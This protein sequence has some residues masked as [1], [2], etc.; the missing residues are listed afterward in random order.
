ML[1]QKYKMLLILIINIVNGRKF[2]LYEK[3]EELEKGEIKSINIES[4]EEYINYIKKFNNIQ[5]LFHFDLCGHCQHFLPI[6]DKASSYKSLNK[7]WIFLKIDCSKYP[8][9]CSFL[10][11][12]RYPTIKLYWQKKLLH[13]EPPRDLVPL[14]E[15]L[16]KLSSSPIIKI[17]SKN[18]FFQK[19]G[20]FSPLIEILPKYIDGKEEESEF[21]NCIKNLAY[22]EL[23]ETFFFGVM[24]S[25]DDKEK[26]VFNYNNFNFSYIWDGQCKNA[27]DFLNNNKYPLISKV[28]SYYLKEIAEDFKILIFLI[29]FPQNKIIHNFIF[30]FFEKISYENRQYVFG[31]ADFNKDK[32]IN[33]YFKLKLNNTNEMK[34][35]IYDFNERMYYIHN[36]TF[37]FKA[38]NEIEIFNEIESLVKNINNLEY[39]TGSIFKDWI[40]KIGFERMSATKQVIIVGIFIFLLLGIFFLCSYLSNSRNSLEDEDDDDDNEDE[41]LLYQKKD[42][43]NISKKYIDKNKNISQKEKNE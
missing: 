24:K 16:H 43:E 7:N 5:N 42:N 17:N 25:K 13:I 31:Y 27:F 37:N 4:S 9:I 39:T 40:S 22:K 26:I 35:I 2:P 29:T 38:N 20:E 3:I 33:K 28:D 32:D 36:K 6:L 23:I 19:Y 14:L 21:F 30:S 11:I 18:K 8:G 41:S 12:E 10:G 15:L 34:L 1:L